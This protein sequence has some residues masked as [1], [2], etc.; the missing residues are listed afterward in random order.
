MEHT[1]KMIAARERINPRI[2]WHG[3][4][5]VRKHILEKVEFDQEMKCLAARVKVRWMK[6]TRKRF[7]RL[8]M[9]IGIH[10]RD[11][12]MLAGVAHERGI[13]YPMAF[14][15]VCKA[16]TEDEEPEESE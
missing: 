5:K 3:A 11:A 2:R 13:P 16:A 7:V 6:M 9:A 4:P 10:A 14:E 15:L 12:Y 8:L 1:I